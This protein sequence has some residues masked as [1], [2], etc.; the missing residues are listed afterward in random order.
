[1]RTEV[2]SLFLLYHLNYVISKAIYMKM[3]SLVFP[4]FMGFTLHA[5]CY[6]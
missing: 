5:T 1:M 2:N 6:R 3:V 4:I